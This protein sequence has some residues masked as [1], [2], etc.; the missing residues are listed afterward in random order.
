M[1]RAVRIGFF[2]DREQ[3]AVEMRIRIHHRKVAN[4]FRE[5]DFV[6]L[7]AE[8]DLAAEVIV[9]FT[10]GP[11]GRVR[12]TQ[13]LR[14]QAYTRELPDQAHQDRGPELDLMAVGVTTHAGEV[15]ADAHRRPADEFLYHAFIHQAAVPRSALENFPQCLGGCEHVVKQTHGAR[16]AELCQVKPEQLVL[17]RRRDE[18]E[19]FHLVANPYAHSRVVD[20]PPRQSAALENWRRGNADRPGMRESEPRHDPERARKLGA[21]FHVTRSVAHSDKYLAAGDKPAGT[22]RTYKARL[23]NR[24]RAR[25]PGQMGMEKDRKT[26]AIIDDD[27]GIRQALRRIL[28]SAGFRAQLFTSAE[29][30][31]AAL[32]TCAAGCAVIDLE[33]GSMSGFELASHPDVV[34]ANLPII[35]ISGTADDTARATAKLL[36]CVEYLRKPFMPIELLGA[37][38]R[39]IQDDIQTS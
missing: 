18:I 20:L 21:P 2:A 11:F 39:A 4:A 22:R 31:L 10:D 23:F 34:R 33:L 7:G 36:G 37:I 12:E 25:A 27:N 1:L 8:F 19:E 28:N 38:F 29:E 35:F 5:H 24:G 26:I 30:F 14:R 15:R 9:H 3:H 17:R 13:A 32:P 6:G 16:L